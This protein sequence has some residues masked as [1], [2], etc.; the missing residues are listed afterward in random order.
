MFCITP[1]LD[2]Y[3]NSSDESGPTLPDE[4]TAYVGFK[5]DGVPSYV[6][7]SEHPDIYQYGILDVTFTPTFEEN[8]KFYFKWNQ[9]I[10]IKV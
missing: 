1:E 7:V 6:N 3:V 8:Q 9:R 4:F 2:L 10:H 5:L